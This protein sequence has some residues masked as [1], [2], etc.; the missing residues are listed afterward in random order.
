MLTLSA[1]LSRG[2]VASC[3]ARSLHDSLC[4]DC[5]LYDVFQLKICI[6]ENLI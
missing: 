4:R 2:F 1:L 3:C 6:G 5:I